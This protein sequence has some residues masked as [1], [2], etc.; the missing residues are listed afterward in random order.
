MSPQTKRPVLARGGC[1]QSTARLTP[2]SHVRGGTSNTSQSGSHRSDTA[3]DRLNTNV[4]LLYL[5]FV[6]LDYIHIRSTSTSKAYNISTTN[7]E[8]VRPLS[9]Y[10]QKRF[11][12]KLS[13][14][15]TPGRRWRLC[16]PLLSR[17]MAAGGVFVR[18]FVL[19]G[20][21]PQTQLTHD[22]NAAAKTGGRNLFVFQY[23]TYCHK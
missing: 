22:N 11:Q 5:L 3:R 6:L 18:V 20:R 23:C 2:C 17:L 13:M 1:R 7:R 21:H 12:N 15:V 19:H 8:I 9:S 4:L 16:S 10:I 14:F